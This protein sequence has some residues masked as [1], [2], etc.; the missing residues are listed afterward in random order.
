S[1]LVVVLVVI[2][3]SGLLVLALAQQALD[4]YER[5]QS[6]QIG[7]QGPIDFV[8]RSVPALTEFLAGHGIDFARVRSAMEA[9]AVAVTQRIGTQA[10]SIGQDAITAAI[11]FALM[12]YLLFF[13]FRD[14]DQIM[15]GVVRALPMGDERE[16]RMFERFADVSRATVKGTL[17]VAA[18]QGALGGVMFG[19]LGLQAAVFW[20]VAM[21]VLSLLPAVGPAL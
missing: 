8:Q 6:G 11:L 9:A 13:F 1:T 21:G 10:L 3:P 18:V 15:A 17:V 4:L 7:I 12:L 20:G 19:V 5:L 2:I 16:M 14:G